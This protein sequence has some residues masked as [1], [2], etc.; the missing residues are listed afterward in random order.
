MLWFCAVQF[1]KQANDCFGLVILRRSLD[2]L[3]RRLQH[4]LCGD[5]SPSAG[6]D[7]VD[8]VPPLD[9]AFSTS[10]ES[11]GREL[12][13]STTR[14]ETT[15]DICRRSLDILRSPRPSPDTAIHIVYPP[16]PR[17]RPA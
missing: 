16:R 17:A 1:N 5:D 6:K 11:G 13:P 15:Y 8:L 4:L 7:I 12:Y 3:L 2:V 9:D 14:R 10:S